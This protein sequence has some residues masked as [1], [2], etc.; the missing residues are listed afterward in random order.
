[1]AEFT[2]NDA[3]IVE[4]NQNVLLDTTIACNK[5]YIL[6][7]NGSGIVILR[8]IV[9]NACA[10]FARYN[11]LFSGNIAVPEG[12]TPGEISLSLALDGEPI[13]TSKGI[14]TPAVVDAYGNVSCPAIIDVP[15]GCCFT[16]AVENTSATPTD[17][18]APAISV[19]N[20]NLAVSRIA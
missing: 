18:A 19:Q 3:Q 12:G 4:S 15:R 11:L 13:Q 8:G 1:M 2:K 9:N 14:F 20:A 10:G 6:H 16:V 17:G 5:G 7:R